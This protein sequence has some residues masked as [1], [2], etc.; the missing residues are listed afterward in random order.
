LNDPRS[1]NGHLQAELSHVS[2]GSTKPGALERF[3]RARLGM[4]VSERPSDDLVRLGLGGDGHALEISAGHGLDHFALRLS[5]DDLAVWE[6]RLRDA[7]VDCRWSTPAGAHPPCLCLADPDGNRIELHSEDGHPEGASHDVPLRPVRVH[8]IT[9]RSAHLP[10]M[11]AFY[12]DVLGFRISDEMGNVFTW[13]R[14]NREHHTV[15]V[16][17]GDRPGMDHLAFEI[18]GWQQLERWC[19][20]LAA[21]DVPLTWGPG[22]HGPGS[23]IFVMFD[24][25][26]ANRVELS[27]EM[28]RFWDGR[29]EYPR[30]PR[31]WPVSD[32]TVNLWGPTPRWRGTGVGTGE[33]KAGGRP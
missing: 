22:R 16:V 4:S 24:D 2:L 23:N 31:R 21:A 33:A 3:Y 14:C 20:M 30:V 12:V 11:V 9:L 15:A 19:D 32:L 5:D 27:C 28:E 8:H 26:D 1:H 10:R 6:P 29:A 25:P 13:L 7:G 18:G 17:S